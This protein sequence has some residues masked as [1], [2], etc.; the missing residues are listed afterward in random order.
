MENYYT[1]MNILDSI[2]LENRKPSDDEISELNM[3]LEQCDFELED[4]SD[5][6]DL[7]M[8]YGLAN[9]FEDVVLCLIENFKSGE[10]IS[11]E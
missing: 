1:M 6:N 4:L 9:N 10:R 2:A 11:L 8:E 3:I 5:A 7:Y